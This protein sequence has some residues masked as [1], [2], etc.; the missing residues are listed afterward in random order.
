MHAEHA[1]NGEQNE[2]S[3]RMIGYQFAVPKARA[4]KFRGK[5]PGTAEQ[6]KP[7]H[8]ARIAFLHPR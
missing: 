2:P 3:E 8:F 5:V 1:D 7:A 4:L 6:T